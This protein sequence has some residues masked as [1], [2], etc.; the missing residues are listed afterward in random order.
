M[1]TPFLTFC[2]QHYV[3]EARCP[4]CTNECPE[5][6]NCRECLER[7]FFHEDGRTYACRNILLFYSCHYGHKYSSEI[8]YL[9]D[10]NF[11]DALTEYRVLSLGAGSC[12]DFLG[13]KD[14]LQ[15]RNRQ[16]HLYYHAI[17]LNNEWSDQN[18]WLEENNG[19]DY[20]VGYNDVYEFLNH[21]DDI[22]NNFNPNIIIIS[23][24]ISD[25]INSNKDVNNFITLVSQMFTQLAA[26]SVII[27]NDYNNGKD[28]RYPRF[29]YETF[30]TDVRKLNQVEVFRYH[31]V[32][33][34]RRYWR[35]GLQHPNNAVLF[36]ISD[37]INAFNPWLFCTSAQLL[38]R[39]TE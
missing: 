20:S 15:L 9:F 18:N 19:E 36:P 11:F 25:L 16:Q 6:G 34:N 26:N 7:M 5:T 37:N 4:D 28:N 12:V 38:I 30:A 31:F 1:L 32:N 39:K 33:N 21:P 23:Y 13:I 8:A 14:L 29:Y 22:I 24:L 2:V 17:E 10:M 35:Y 27:I 3:R